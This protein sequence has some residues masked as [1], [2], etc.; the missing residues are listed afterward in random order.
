MSCHHHRHH[1]FLQHGAQDSKPHIS[2]CLAWGGAGGSRGAEG[3]VGKGAISEIS[4][5]LRNITQNP[6]H[7]RVPVYMLKTTHA[8]VHAQMRVCPPCAHTYRHSNELT[9]MSTDSTCTQT[10]LCSRT[11]TARTRVHRCLSLSQ[12]QPPPLIQVSLESLG[13]RDS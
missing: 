12:E 9:D 13:S 10:H 8:L 7:A 2:S 6:L 5:D 4:I 11:Q 1:D 3:T